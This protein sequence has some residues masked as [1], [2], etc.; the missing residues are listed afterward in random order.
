MVKLCDEKGQKLWVTLI[1]I[2]SGTKNF[3]APYNI[4]NHLLA[5]NDILGSYARASLSAQLSKIAKFYHQLPDPTAREI[6]V[7]TIFYKSIMDE[8]VFAPAVTAY[9][10]DVFD[11]V[12]EHYQSCDYQVTG[13][14]TWKILRK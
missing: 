7:E 13:D 6:T 12:V 9:Y 1:D 3:D 14:R 2:F 10:S 4:F 8:G 11:V 5:R